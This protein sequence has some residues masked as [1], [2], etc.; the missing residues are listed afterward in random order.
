MGRWIRFGN[1]LERITNVLAA[2]LTAIMAIVVCW[3][4]FARYVLN[5]GQFWAEEFAVICMFWLALLG[6]AGAL[7][8][9]DHIGL[10]VIVDRLPKRWRGAPQVASE[11]LIGVFAV[12]LFFQ[13]LELVA[14]TS[15]GDWSA[16]RVP[17]GYTY[18]VLPISAAL[19]AILS[20]LK[21]VLRTI[22]LLGGGEI[23][24]RW[25]TDLEE[26]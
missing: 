5:T 25:S 1:V 4:V 18:V 12:L 20:L 11:L 14:R 22:F 19:M 2:F 7:W 21:G 10:R 8:S 26:R 6:A 17:L 13:G 9:G 15:G 3:Q 24:R 23:P 16:L